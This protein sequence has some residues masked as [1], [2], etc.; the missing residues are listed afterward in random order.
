MELEQRE[1]VKGKDDYIAYLKEML[2]QN[3]NNHIG[4]IRPEEDFCDSIGSM[5]E[6]DVISTEETEEKDGA[7][8]QN[9]DSMTSFFKKMLW[10]NPSS[11]N[12]PAVQEEEEEHRDCARSLEGVDV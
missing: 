12:N 2:Q 5:E 3:P 8:K 10:Q 1:R 11:Q 6:D 9:L 4:S 7:E